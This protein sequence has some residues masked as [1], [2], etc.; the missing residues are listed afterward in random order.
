MKRKFFAATLA[1]LLVFQLVPLAYAGSP[2]T[3]TE[4]TAHAVNQPSENLS[5]DTAG[6]AGLDAAVGGVGGSG[7]T[8]AAEGSKNTALGEDANLTVGAP[9]SATSPNQAPDLLEAS[10]TIKI[11]GLAVVDGFVETDE[12]LEES[13]LLD[14]SVDAMTATLNLLDQKSLSYT[15]AY[16]GTMLDSISLGG[17][18]LGSASSGNNYSYWELYVDGYSSWVGAGATYAQ[19][20]AV[21]EWRYND[22]AEMAFIDQAFEVKITG[23]ESIG[24]VNV[25]VPWI[26]SVKYYDPSVDVL[27][28]TGAVLDRYSMAYV[29]GYNDTYLESITKADGLV[30]LASASSGSIW[31]YWEFFVNNSSSWFGADK[32]MPL[33]GDVFEFKYYLGGVDAPVEVVVDPSATRPHYS[34]DNAGFVTNRTVESQTPYEPNSTALAFKTSIKAAD[35]WTIGY[36]DLLLVNGNV[37]VAVGQSLV[38]YSGTTGAKLAEAQ[39]ANSVGYT[40]RPLYTQG[41]VVVPLDGGRLQAFTADTLT[42]VWITDVLP[43]TAN[44]FHQSSSTLIEQNGLIYYGTAVA[45]YATS[46]AGAFMCIDASTGEILWQVDNT[47]SGY[48]W[49]GAIVVGEYVYIADDAGNLTSYSATGGWQAS[50]I[51]L[52][53]SIRSTLTS[54]GEYLYALDYAGTLWRV[55]LGSWGA[56][57]ASGSIRLGISSTSTPV[58]SNGKLFVGATAAGYSGILAVIDVDS[59]TLERS[60]S[61]PASVQS[62]PLVSVQGSNTYVYFTCNTTPGGVYCYRLGDAAASELFAPTGEDANYC[63]STVVASASGMLYY[64]NDS[65]QLFAL[66]VGQGPTISVPSPGEGATDDGGN[67]QPT[68][69]AGGSVIITVIDATTATAA[70]ENASA[71]SEENSATT[72]AANRQ[73]SAANSIAES[74]TPESAPLVDASIPLLPI[75][76]ISVAVVGLLVAGLWALRARSSAQK[77]RALR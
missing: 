61:V 17:V 72:S 4:T 18:T 53:T 47:A 12:W 75:L 74:A 48:Y 21:W 43:A 24:G 23:V 5:G 66:N 20:G 10:V 60:I 13:V 46:T 3:P 30:T 14:T 52:G 36:S 44:G 34:A 26:K 1:L 33:P 54:D 77:G 59:F 11:T 63:M 56:L 50:S 40:S 70:Q 58:L 38:V 29:L 39:L 68:V 31:S 16:G 35:D 28:A 41:L 57:Q 6:D 62:T 19:E 67:S 51:N 15:T 73:N 69:I 55:S 45:D 42:C 32:T 27:T 9:L 71:T 7:D 37:Y 49:A 76:G 8:D 25:Y 64:V 2:D 22:A 65:G